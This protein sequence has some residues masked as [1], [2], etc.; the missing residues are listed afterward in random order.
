MYDELL[1]ILNGNL[2]KMYY[3]RNLCND[4][5]DVDIYDLS[6]FID[7]NLVRNK[8]KASFCN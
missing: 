2:N 7:I 5:N 4:L 1:Q 6:Y 3:P 8:E